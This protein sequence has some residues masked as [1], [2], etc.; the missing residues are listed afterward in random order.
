ME[1]IYSVENFEA[2]KGRQQFQRINSPRSLE[3]CLRLGYD[4]SELNP[5]E[6]KDL[7]KENPSL[8]A[9]MV[10][11]MYNQFEHKRNVK[12]DQVTREREAIIAS[13]L[14]KLN[15]QASNSSGLNATATATATAGG[16][17]MNV[18]TRQDGEVEK[19]TK[20][21]ALALE[22]KRMEALR[23]RQEAELAKIVEREQIMATLQAKI[24]KAED[25]EY[26]KMQQHEK[27]V[28]AQKVLDMKKAEQRK[29]E[30]KRLL[31][32]E[33]AK[34]REMDKKEAAVAVKLI[35]MKKEED[36][37][38]ELEAL[39]REVERQQKIE[40]ARKKTEA[41]IQSQFDK[42]EENRR[43]MVEREERVR[44]Q[45]DEKKKKKTREVQEARQKAEKRIKAAI[46]QSKLIQQKKKEDFDGRNKIA[47]E[48]AK[49]LHDE[50]LEKAKKDA[51]ERE[52][53]EK[54]RIQRLVDSYK[55]RSDHRKELISSFSSK[56]AIFRKMKADQDEKLAMIKFHT[57]LKL[58]DKLDNVDRQ[59]RQNEFQRLTW[60]KKIEDED[61]KYEMIQD[62]KKKL[63]V[64]HALE[65]KSSL[66]RKHEIS[67]TMEKMRQT[68]D[69]TL[70]D[71]LF[72]KK[73]AEDN[74]NKSAKRDDEDVYRED[75]PL[76]MPD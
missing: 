59:A 28:A 60:L 51:D 64:N 66:I 42:A 48:R 11:I 20:S 70:L 67:E 8:T 15:L 31:E 2:I 24:K 41:L 16:G 57:E 29:A 19:K 52:K 34:T 35:K 37:R 23:K 1:S 7:K 14:K 44:A 68:N 53:A 6:K 46:E 27:K 71:K 5:K 10:D 21:A 50:M 47:L 25:D 45:L 54:I 26:A 56:D 17:G 76:A 12:K 32:E 43:I 9:E 73:A 65:Q 4:P 55:Q 22:E 63:E 49:L 30:A 38:I 72:V 75:A 58:S 40:E 18:K 69:F 3:A 36:K 74:K 61:R 39:Q 62:A 13:N 33:A